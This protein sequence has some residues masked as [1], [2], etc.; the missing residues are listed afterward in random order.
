[1]NINFISLFEAKSIFVEAL[2]SLTQQ[3]KKILGI[4]LAAFA[5]LALTYFII[6]RCC[7]KAKP[8]NNE[9]EINIPKPLVV[10]ALMDAPKIQS[11]DPIFFLIPSDLELNKAADVLE[12][13]T[14]YK[15]IVD[16]N[17]LKSN[18]ITKADTWEEGEREFG[19]KMKD[20]GIVHFN[21]MCTLREMNKG[22]VATFGVISHPREVR[23]IAQ[24]APKLY[25]GINPGPKE[26]IGTHVFSE[27][28]ND[29]TLKDACETL[30][31]RTG[32]HWEIDGKH[33][34]YKGFGDGAD[35]Q[36]AEQNLKSK[37]KKE[38]GHNTFNI[39]TSARG[40][41]LTATCVCWS[42]SEIL[43]LAELNHPQVVFSDE[44]G[45]LRSLAT[46]AATLCVM[47]DVYS[48]KDFEIENPDYKLPFPL[49]QWSD[50]GLTIKLPPGLVADINMIDNLQAFVGEGYEEITEKH[51][52]KDYIAKVTVPWEKV[53]N[54]IR[55]DLELGKVSIAG[56]TFDM[57][58]DIIVVKKSSTTPFTNEQEKFLR[59]K[60]S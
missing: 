6:R 54:F 36:E 29:E 51:F 18:C 38:V 50:A 24:M 19:Q 3:Q 11:I 14:G 45:N 22:E 41:C 42:P 26:I 47:L 5:C 34:R 48:K 44:N 27:K 2:R 25:G 31:K 10:P 13:A 52:N 20:L 12:K 35:W 39:L 16:N 28:I 37:L 56:K 58:E 43:R 49:L 53:A 8:L 46:I 32:L 7:F 60:K 33:L 15:W 55:N 1:M 30:C 40:G 21:V 17:C 57:V 59:S 4:C 9:R 23:K